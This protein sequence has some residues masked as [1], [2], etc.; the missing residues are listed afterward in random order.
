MNETASPRRPNILLVMFDQLAPQS[1]PSYGHPIVQA[2]NLDHLS[3]GESCS[4]TRTAIRRFAP[5]LGSP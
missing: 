5:H 4:R 2:P 1:L 3:A